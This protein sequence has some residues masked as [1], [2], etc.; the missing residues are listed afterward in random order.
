[1][2]RGVGWRGKGSDQTKKN[3][4][5][6]KVGRREMDRRQR[7]EEECAAQGT[8]ARDD[9]DVHPSI[10]GSLS[11]TR[12]LPPP[13]RRQPQ[14]SLHNNRNIKSTKHSGFIGNTEGHKTTVKLAV[15]FASIYVVLL[16]G[17]SRVQFSPTPFTVARPI[18]TWTT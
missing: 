13:T 7:D 10:H 11:A 2:R 4:D 16:L 14:Q 5:K 15:V 9:K 1:M 12:I 8:G 18:Y 17:C 6:R 3:R